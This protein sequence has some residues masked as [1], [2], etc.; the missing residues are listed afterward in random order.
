MLHHTNSWPTRYLPFEACSN[1]EGADNYNLGSML[2]PNSD[3]KERLGTYI[4]VNTGYF[5]KRGCYV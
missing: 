3:R 4:L 2:A 5:L 1:R